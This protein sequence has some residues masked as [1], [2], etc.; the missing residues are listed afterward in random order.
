MSSLTDRNPPVWLRSLRFGK[1][2]LTSP[3]HTMMTGYRT[4]TPFYHPT[5]TLP[6]GRLPR[7]IRSLIHG[8]L[9]A[10]YL[11]SA[12][13]CLSSKLSLELYPRVNLHVELDQGKGS[14]SA[15]LVLD[16][17]HFDMRPGVGRVFLTWRIGFPWPDRHGL[18][19]LSL[20]NSDME[21][22]T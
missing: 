1:I 21:L 5:S 18:P 3:E 2:E 22:V 19:T 6:S 15:P 9:V 8:W 16:G 13:F 10:S 20:A 14:Q 4:A 7:K 11:N 17:V 12:D